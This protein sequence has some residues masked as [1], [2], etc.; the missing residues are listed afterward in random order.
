VA[1]PAT[2][3]PVQILGPVGA[4]GLPLGDQN[5]SAPDLHLNDDRRRALSPADKLQTILEDANSYGGE[6]E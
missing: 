1:D 4:D 6:R 3:N 5:K 2:P